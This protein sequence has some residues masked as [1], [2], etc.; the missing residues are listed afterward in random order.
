MS[1]GCYGRSTERLKQKQAIKKIDVKTEG[2]SCRG[3]DVER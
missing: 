1:T 2:A 3:L